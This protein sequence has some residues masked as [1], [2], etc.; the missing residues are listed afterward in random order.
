[1]PLI[2]G[3]H[4]IQLKASNSS[5]AANIELESEA[6]SILGETLC[7]TKTIY[8]YNMQNYVVAFY[9]KILRKLNNTGIYKSNIVNGILYA[10]SQF[11]VFG[12]YAT[13]FYAGGKFFENGTVSLKNMMRAILIILFSALGVGIAQ[14]FVGDYSAAQKGIVGLYDFLDEKS[15][16]DVEE[17]CEKGFSIVEDEI[18]S[19]NYETNKNEDNEHKIKLKYEYNENKKEEINK[20][21]NDEK[22]N[23]KVLNNNEIPK[24]TISDNNNKDNYNSKFRGKIEFRNVRFFYPNNERN[25]VF[26]NLNFTIEPG[27]SAAFVGPSGSGKSTI[28]SLI[29]RFYDVC[30][31]E[32][33]IDERNIREYN[34]VF[35]RRKIGTVLQEP[36]IFTREIKENIRYG[37]LEATDEQIQNAAKKAFIEN[38]LGNANALGSGGEMQRVA[39]AR[40]ILKDPA[41]LLLDEAT[42][43]LDANLEEHIKR[44]LRELM[45]NRTS[46]AVAHRYFFIKF[47]YFN[48]CFDFFIRKIL[49]IKSSKKL[50]I[51][52][53]R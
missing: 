4:V 22:N 37:N 15:L 7:N 29:E 42:S 43:A 51:F 11:I 48:Y 10:F 2:I 47:F 38:S 26:N 19:E 39:I 5:S 23:N 20:N 6:A 9:A 24:N 49:F 25:S 33:L 30:S 31:G 16:I 50:F 12:M 27:Q 13:L 8:A 36:G 21:Y 52:I 17:S 45:K 46:I 44:S 35:L 34:L 1:M 28:I 32:I 41:I 53:I 3:T 40:A 18:K 14:A